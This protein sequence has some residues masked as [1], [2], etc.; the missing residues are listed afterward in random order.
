MT[1]LYYVLVKESER[2]RRLYVDCY[3]D[4]ET[5]LIRQYQLI[6]MAFLNLETDEVKKALD[7]IRSDCRI[8]G[9]DEI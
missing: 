2:N 9:V 3:I 6:D 4:K 7:T 5:L 1:K 8:C